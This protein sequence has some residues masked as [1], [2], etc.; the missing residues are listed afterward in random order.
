MNATTQSSDSNNDNSD[1]QAKLNKLYKDVHEAE[2]FVKILPVIEQEMLSLLNAERL[3]V[4]QRGRS[5]HELVSRYKTG[6]DINEIRV[7]LSTSSIAGYVALSQQSM[8]IK[9]VYDAD[10]LGNIHPKLHFDQSYDQ[11]SGWRS[12]SMVVVPIKFK[13]TLLGLLQIINGESRGQ[14]GQKD[15][16]CAEELAHLIGQK[17]QYDLQATQGP[18]DHLINQG[19]LAREKL[20]DFVKRTRKQKMSVASL[21]MSELRITREEIGESLKRF[22]QVPFMAFDPSIEIPTEL[23][24][25]LNTSYLRSSRWVPISGNKDKVVILIDDPNDYKRIM[26]AQ[27]V[28]KVHRC[29]IRVGIT[30][31]I[32]RFLGEG[33]TQLDDSIDQGDISD[34][35][36]RLESEVDI[37]EEDEAAD[38]ALNE[39]NSAVI[40]LVNRIISDACKLNGSDIHIEP[41]KG[42][43]DTVVRVRVDGTCR[44]VL[45][46]PS[47]HFRAV[48][49]RIKIMAKLD[50]SERRKPQDG[51]I[52]AKLQGKPIE[53]RVATIPT[54]NGE[55]AVLRV[56]ASGDALSMSDLNLSKHN[57]DGIQNIVA[58]PHGIF[59]VVGPTGSGKTTTLHAILGHLN[60]PDRKIW[61]A[62]DPVEITQPGLQQVQTQAAI[63][64]TFAAA[65]RSFLRA[66]PDVILIG[67]MR[68][69]ETSHIGVEAS[70]TGHLVLSTLHTNS[71][72][73]TIT[74]LLGLGLDPMDF[75]DA[76]LG[77]LAQR[78]VKTL[79]KSCKEEYE[80]ATEEIDQLDKASGDSSIL[81]KLMLERGGALKLFRAKGCDDCGQSG[82]RGRTGI[83]EL[84]ISTPEI[85]KAIATNSTIAEIRDI[86]MKQGMRTLVQDGVAKIINGDTDL[87]Q[88]RKTVSE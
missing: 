40:Q 68:D 59:L 65:L 49:S 55:S 85:D 67:E 7:D 74:R 87:L 37:A 69:K 86:A 31:D 19:V 9:D 4:Y 45:R 53:L 58:H 70:L 26:E 50:I 73:E 25:N 76:F 83:H 35:V 36:D 84:L 18:Y 51:K 17:F 63:G 46:I 34:I 15:L 72:P 57:L 75:A 79:C 78:L 24:E 43:N 1:Y 41:G 33:G 14:F 6:Q 77:V 11:S 12:H 44:E 20:N 10:E 62:E 27:Q 81:Q 66:D 39:N 13:E 28:M 16:Q 80:P 48:I 30:E 71:A 21:L 64:F 2:S 32:L 5:D 38:N 54:V 56:L 82:Y 23:F 52:A 42:K 29:E 61:T 88:L 3:T 8:L 60:T 47:T 22:Y